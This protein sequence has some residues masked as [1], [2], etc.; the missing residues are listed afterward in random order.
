MTKFQATRTG[1]YPT[2]GFTAT[3][4]TA[5]L[6]GS[7]S[8]PVLTIPPDATWSVYGGG[9]AETGITRYVA[10]SATPI[11]P[12][13]S[14][15]DGWFIAY[16]SSQG[17]GI[18]QNPS[19]LAALPS[20]ANTFAPRA[21]IQASEGTAVTVFTSQPA[22]YS[23]GRAKFATVQT[24]ASF[25]GTDSVP[26]VDPLLFLGYNAEVASGGG[27]ASEPMFAMGFEGNYRA[28]NWAGTGIQQDTMEWYMEYRN[29]NRSITDFRP[30]A[31]T[32]GR[33]DNTA[34]WATIQLEIGTDA[35]GS[36]SQFFI[37]GTNWAPTGAG[38]TTT[39]LLNANNSMIQ[40]YRDTYFAGRTLNMVSFPSSSNAHIF[41]THDNG[42]GGRTTNFYLGNFTG[43]ANNHYLYNN[44]DD[45]FHVKYTK[46]ATDTAAATEFQ[47]NVKVDGG[48]NVAQKT[49]ASASATGT[50]GDVAWDT[51]FIYVCTATNTWKRA[52]VA[53]W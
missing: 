18:Y 8:S 24:S 20:W 16:S 46:G 21:G 22:S 44:A 51:G 9:S 38:F 49:P 13:P 35:S 17:T 50:T 15:T 4:A 53:T 29:A 30:I 12:T 37:K 33:D 19:T 28:S 40:I 47:S 25:L 41:F 3:S 39:S 52:A 27:R 6:D 23:V 11:V 48:L 42:S 43:D 14:V 1:D 45:R 32:I 31:M 5:I 10:P 26:V 7:L 34:R 36:K 2:L